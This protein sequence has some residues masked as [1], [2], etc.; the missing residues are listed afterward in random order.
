MKEIRENFGVIIAFLLPGFLLLWGLSFSFENVAQWL[1]ASSGEE[2]PAIGEFLYATLASLALG[3]LISAFRWATID[4]LLGRLGVKDP[5]LDF[6]KLKE[7]DRYEAFIGAVENHY[8]FYQYYSNTLI[9]IVLA[10]FFDVVFGELRPSLL[11]WVSVGV[12]VLV[13]FFASRDTLAK[14]Y[15]RAGAILK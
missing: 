1:A 11:V 14:Y 15:T 3:L 2:A 13:L 9:A 8:R 6:G 4:T 7:K 12:T 10:L 5:G